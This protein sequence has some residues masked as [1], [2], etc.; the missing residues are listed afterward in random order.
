MNKKILYITWT[1]ALGSALSGVFGCSG[2][3][4]AMGASQGGGQSAGCGYP[5]TNCPSGYVPTPGQGGQC[6]PSGAVGN[7]V[8]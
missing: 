4:G 3:G 6:M 8:P 5:S 7:G 2:M 1:L